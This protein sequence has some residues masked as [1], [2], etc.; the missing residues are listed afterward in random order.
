MTEIWLVRHG[1]T[2]G[3][4]HNIVQGQMDI[5]LNETGEAQARTLADQLADVT[6]AA[7]Y[8]SDLSRAMQTASIIASKKGLTVVPD[9]RLREIRQGIW[10]G[11]PF[12]QVLQIHQPD[13]SPNPF[14]VTNPRAE[15]AESLAEVVARMVDAAN[16]YHARHPGERVLI[17]VLKTSLGKGHKTSGGIDSRICK[18]I[19]DRNND[20]SNPNIISVTSCY[21]QVDN[22]AGLCSRPEPCCK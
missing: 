13:F 17:R 16:E 9:P 10:E 7:I 21:A 8:S 2:D 1:Q 3:N 14:Y 18:K 22:H 4:L 19:S 15:G 12:E 11:L 6:F 20:L 5:P